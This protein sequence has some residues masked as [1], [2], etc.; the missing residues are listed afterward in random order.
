MNVTGERIED[1]PLVRIVEVGPDQAE[2]GGPARI[3]L[4]VQ[5]EMFADA[6]Q[7]GVPVWAKTV[8]PRTVARTTG[9]AV[10][11]ARP[12]N[13]RRVVSTA[14]RSRGDGSDVGSSRSGRELSAIVSLPPVFVL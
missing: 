14:S 8:R 6:G 11:A 13:T 1:D 3:Y 4:P 5:E 12:K 9:S 2:A 7:L 10:T